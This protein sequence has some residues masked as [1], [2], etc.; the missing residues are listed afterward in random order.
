MRAVLTI[1]HLTLAEA[2]RRLSAHYLPELGEELVSA[3]LCL[4]SGDS[5]AI[6]QRPGC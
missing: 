4:Y 1:A 2:R 5:S 6:C 3:G